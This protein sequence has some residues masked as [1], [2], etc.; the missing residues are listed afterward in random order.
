MA[1]LTRWFRSLILNKA[2]DDGGKGQKKD[3]KR[4]APL[5][6]SYKKKIHAQLVSL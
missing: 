3:L 5:S 1:L 6:C 2:Y 4:K